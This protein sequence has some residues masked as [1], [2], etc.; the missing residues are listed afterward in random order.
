MKLMIFHRTLKPRPK[1]IPLPLP[2][3]DGISPSIKAET[4]RN[5]DSEFKIENPKLSIQS[6]KAW[7]SGKLA[8]KGINLDVKENC[9]TALI[10]PSGC[11]KT[12]LLRCINRMHDLTPNAYS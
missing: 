1:L 3:E 7:F 8:L 12:T 11:G 9:V 10:G 5:F 4:E 6:L 2:L